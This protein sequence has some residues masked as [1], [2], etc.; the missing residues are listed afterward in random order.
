MDYSKK[1]V[2]ELI[3]LCK[4]KKIKGYSGKRKNEIISL[5]P[6]E[7]IYEE[8]T[9]CVCYELEANWNGC[10]K[11]KCGHEI[12]MECF[13]KIITQNPKCPLCR[14]DLPSAVIKQ[15]RR[16]G[17]SIEQLQER[18][19]LKIIRLL[20]SKENWMNHCMTCRNEECIRR[21]RFRMEYLENRIIFLTR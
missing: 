8:K 19:R 18:R 17:L 20:Q 11:A 4:E 15:D 21:H 1:T 9:C 14:I 10:T 16:T 7:P 12:C 13:V 2:S 5:I 6:K 3:K